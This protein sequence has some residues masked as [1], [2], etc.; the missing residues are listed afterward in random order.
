MDWAQL[1]RRGHGVGAQGVQMKKNT[2]CSSFLD[3]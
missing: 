2:L 3:S 1:M